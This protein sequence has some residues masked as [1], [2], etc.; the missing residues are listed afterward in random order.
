[1][2][3]KRLSRPRCGCLL[4]ATKKTRT[5]SVLRRRQGRGCFVPLRRLQRPVLRSALPVN[6]SPRHQLAAIQDR[7]G[8]GLPLPRQVSEE[9]TR[10]VCFIFYEADSLNSLKI[11]E[12]RI[13][14]SRFNASRYI[15]APTQRE[16]FW[17][18]GSKAEPS[19]VHCPALR[20]DPPPDPTRPSGAIASHSPCSLCWLPS[21]RTGME[22]SCL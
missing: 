20:C 8:F 10:G 15:Y 4:S 22:Y 14:T 19:H 9:G 1:M 2:G 11:A 21:R 3:A 5:H 6:P 17:I 18:W 12:Q 7:I 16:N 13:V